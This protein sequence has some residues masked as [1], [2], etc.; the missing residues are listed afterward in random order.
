MIAYDP[1]HIWTVPGST[2]NVIVNI[3]LNIDKVAVY[4]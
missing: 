3:S 1:G 4:R 2:V